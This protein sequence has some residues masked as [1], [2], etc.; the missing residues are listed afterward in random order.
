MTTTLCLP[1]TLAGTNCLGENPFLCPSHSVDMRQLLN[2][3]LHFT[4]ASLIIL[5]LPSG[6]NVLTGKHF[7]TNLA[8]SVQ[9]IQQ[10]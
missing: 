2:C 8:H 5:Q 4:A 3:V 7:N 9:T 1:H 10:N 6:N